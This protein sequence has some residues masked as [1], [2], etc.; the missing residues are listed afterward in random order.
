MEEATDVSMRRQQV[1][2]KERYLGDKKLIDSQF[3]AESR[4]F[5]QEMQALNK[6]NTQLESNLKD[7]GFA[8]KEVNQK[9]SHRKSIAN[10]VQEIQGKITKHTQDLADTKLKLSIELDINDVVA[11]DGFPAYYFEEV[12]EEIA[13]EV[14]RLIQLIPNTSGLSFSFGDKVNKTGKVKK[15]ITAMVYQMGVAISYT[16][17]SGGQRSVLELAADLAIREI[18]S[19]RVGVRFNWMVLDE[20]FNGMG[21]KDR[22]SLM[23]FLTNAMGSDTLVLLVDHSVEY[24]DAFQAVIEVKSLNGGSHIG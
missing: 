23:E 16:E 11:K 4:V 5:Y 6:V 9:L 15:S 14:N 10:T 8:I 12:L 21:K 7:V 1:E 19:R 3:E 20:V 24:Q 2:T 13:S 22:D 17:L 18:I